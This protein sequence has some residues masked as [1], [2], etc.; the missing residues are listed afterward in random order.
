M[1][2]PIEHRGPDGDTRTHTT[3][4]GERF[5]ETRIV[6]N[7]VSFEVNSSKARSRRKK[8]A[9]AHSRSQ[10]HKVTTLCALSD[11]NNY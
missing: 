9:R 6:S 3:D 4:D 8:Q 1:C 7:A 2:A 11:N 10:S 5:G